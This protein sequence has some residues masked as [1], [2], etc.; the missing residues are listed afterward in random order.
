ML[1]LS[2][3]SETAKLRRGPGLPRTTRSLK[4]R[5]QPFETVADLYQFDASEEATEKS[6]KTKPRGPRS[7]KSKRSSKSVLPKACNRKERS[8]IRHLQ[9][10]LNLIVQPGEA[11]EIF[12][13]ERKRE[14]LEFK[15]NYIGFYDRDH[16]DDLANDAIECSG[17]ATAV[18]FRMN[19]VKPALLA[20]SAN[21]LQSARNVKPATNEEIVRRRLLDAPRIF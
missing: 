8:A 4:P 10:F 5:R 12:V 20:R 13:K 6:H 18:F 11:T 7:K 14:G 15:T 16:L 3:N 21:R 17:E 1:K 2:E 19:P 9:R